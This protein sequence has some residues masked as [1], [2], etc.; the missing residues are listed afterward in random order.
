MKTETKLLVSG[1]AVVG[2]LSISAFT[3]LV[4]HLVSFTIGQRHVA[5][6][7]AHLQQQ[8]Y[9]AAIPEYTRALQ[10]S[11]GTSSRAYVLASRGLC[12]ARRQ[13]G[14]Q[15]DAIGDLSA[16]LRLND[17]IAYVYLERGTLHANR[18]NYDAAWKD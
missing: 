15:D 16:A 8:R 12:E 14:R 1:A 7:H 17:R 18:G 2:L 13:N 9:D 4:Y 11:I 3:L 6:G 5:R 10:C